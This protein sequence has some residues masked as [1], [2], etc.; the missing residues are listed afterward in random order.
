MILLENC[1]LFGFESKHKSF[2]KQS[3]ECIKYL[4][5]EL[6]KIGVDGKILIHKRDRLVFRVFKYKGFLLNLDI[7]E[8]ESKFDHRMSLNL[9]NNV[10]RWKDAFKKSRF[11]FVE[12]NYPNEAIV[13]S[14][15]ELREIIES[16]SRFSNTMWL[17]Y[18]QWHKAYYNEDISDLM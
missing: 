9:L 11:H 10:I 4:S 5:N 1:A 7:F 2:L 15:K 13:E 14:L 12:E 6:G 8:R 18:A 3:I 16:D 17:T